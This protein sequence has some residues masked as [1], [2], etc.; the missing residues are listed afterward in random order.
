MDAQHLIYPRALPNLIHPK[1]T[2]PADARIADIATGTGAWLLDV[3]REFP[4]NCHL[5]GFD[6]NLAQFPNLRWC[7]PNVTVH[8]WDVYEP[9]RSDFRA[10]YGRQS[11]KNSIDIH[12]KYLHKIS[13]ISTLLGLD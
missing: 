6:I 3:A 4:D 1:I 11:Q 2:L 13:S 5:D 7:P 10:V 8:Q 12:A 9:P